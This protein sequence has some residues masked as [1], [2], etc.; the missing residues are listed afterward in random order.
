[1]HSAAQCCSNCGAV[2][3]FAADYDEPCLALLV[4]TPGPV[5][6][7]L[8]PVP[9]RLHDLPAIAAGPVD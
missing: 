5:E 6:M 8:Q 4:G 3:A 1:V 7:M 9:D 2:E